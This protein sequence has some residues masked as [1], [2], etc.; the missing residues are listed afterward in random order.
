MERPAKKPR[1]PSSFLS[2]YKIH[3]LLMQD[4]DHSDTLSPS[5]LKSLDRWIVCVMLVQFDIN[6]GPDLKIIQPPIEFTESDFSKLCFSAL[7]ERQLGGVDTRSEYHSFRFQS[8]TFSEELHGFALFG[9]RKQDGMVRGY[10]QE[11]WVIVS[12]F[13]F[14][15]LFNNCLRRMADEAG[16]NVLIDE[17]SSSV[18]KR[19][20]D[21]EVPQDLLGACLP[22]IYTGLSNIS[23]WPDPQSSSILELGFLGTVITLTIPK[24]QST[25][26]IGIMDLNT[27]S[28][29]PRFSLSTSNLTLSSSLNT[30]NNHITATD[31]SESWDYM[32]NFVSDLSDLYIFYEYMILAKPILVY[33]SSPHL[34]SSLISL[35][36]DLIRPIFPSNRIREYVTIQTCPSDLDN[37]IT[38][39]TNPFLVHGVQH[40]DTLV[41]IMT[42]EPEQKRMFLA[43]FSNRSNS[44]QNR[45]QSTLRQSQ[46]VASMNNHS[47]TSRI[48]A[49]LG[50]S[51]DR[52]QHR[53]VDKTGI[54]RPI[55]SS[56]AKLPTS[57]TPPPFQVQPPEDSDQLNR[58]EELKLKH[59]L[60]SSMKNILRNRL[61]TPDTKFLASL[62]D[63]PGK[64]VDFAIRYH[65]ASLTAKFLGPLRKFCED[66]GHLNMEEFAKE[67]FMSYLHETKSSFNPLLYQHFINSPNFSSCSLN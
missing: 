24:S 64:S 9:R 33:S 34:C 66:Q 60:K 48:F 22:V 63:L 5:I 14:P 10:I 31:P 27:D 57:Y 7:P 67:Q 12:R 41:Y 47:W 38:G 19:K 53:K 59:S 45:R 1:I 20:L 8:E 30:N 46:S 26:L 17:D 54:S 13:D 36:I 62:N 61:L 56:F 43:P 58:E 51:G 18:R 55:I 42:K 28:I 29:K 11:S 32:M 35:L 16:N 4:S 52:L 50:F 2:S 49:T 65:F 39:L 40:E 25:P 3:E 23:F 21:E 37:G 6:I 44:G 15:K